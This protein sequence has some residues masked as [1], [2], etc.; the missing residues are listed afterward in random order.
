MRRGSYFSYDNITVQSAIQHS[1]V[2]L[3][4]HETMLFAVVQPMARSPRPNDPLQLI[5][6]DPNDLVDPFVAPELFTNQI[7]T[8][9]N[10]FRNKIVPVRESN[11]T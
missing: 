6:F 8:K 5:G 4:A 1:R 9:K 7:R 3:H 2:T 10:E 11:V